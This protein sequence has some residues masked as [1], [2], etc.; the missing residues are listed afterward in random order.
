MLGFVDGI[1]LGCVLVDG[2]ALG[3]PLGLNDGWEEGAFEGCTLGT[4][5]LL[6]ALLGANDGSIDAMTDSEV[7]PVTVRGRRST[8][9]Q[10]ACHRSS[11]DFRAT[12]YASNLRGHFRLEL[13]R[14]FLQSTIHSTIRAN[15]QDCND[16]RLPKKS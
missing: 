7:E 16:Y 3:L 8:F 13:N 15:A 1:A 9:F 12:L 2:C 10:S 5:E 11:I 4:A 6:G 14:A